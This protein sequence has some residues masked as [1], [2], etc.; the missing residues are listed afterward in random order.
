[1]IKY[2]LI[3]KSAYFF[4]EKI[5]AMADL[6]LGYEEN[7]RKQGIMIPSSQFKETIQDLERI[8]SEIKKEKLEIKEVVILGDLKHEFSGNLNQEWQEVHELIS[9][10][11]SKITSKGK[12][13]VIKGNHDNYLA[14]VIKDKARIADFYVKNGICFVHGDKMILEA[15]DKTVEMIVLGHKHPAITLEKSSKKERYKCFLVGK[16]K[17][18]EVIIFPSFF[19][20]VEGSDVYVDDTNLAFKLDLKKFK[21]YIPV[22]GETRVL[23]FKKI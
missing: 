23:E 5:L 6:H 19:P 3:G 14:N 10:L 9:Y 1:M 21:I 7:L 2:K 13:I 12:I 20:L 8:F 15:L 18:K 4:E 16:F 11:Q 17:G 22:P